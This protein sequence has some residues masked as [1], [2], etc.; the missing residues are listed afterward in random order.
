MPSSPQLAVVGPGAI[1]STFASVAE[2]AGVPGVALCGRTPLTRVTVRPDDGAPMVLASEVWT[3]PAPPR[4]PVDW[5]L[6]AVKAHQTEG[7]A[8]WLAS[9]C[10]P[11]TVVVVLQNGVEHRD[12]VAPYV[13]AATVLPAIVWCPAEAG[14]RSGGEQT[15]R[16]RGTPE[17]T[18][19]DEPAGHRLVELLEPG[20]ARIHPT[21][22]F[23][24]EAWRKLT[25]NAMAG[26]MVLTGRRSG[27]FR[28]AD[29][30]EL[31]IRLAQECI[32]VAVAEGA[33]LDCST[34]VTCA[35][36]FAGWPTDLGSSILCD[37]AAA[38]PLEWDARNGVVRRLAARHGIPTPVSDVIV[39]LLAA[40]SD[41]P[42]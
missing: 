21:A 30:R 12:T 28:R 27:M 18:V 14:P 15:I 6:L 19:P 2:R 1:G 8:P 10:G 3:D 34:A 41:D 40:A 5:L 20:G 35:D 22:D 42:S 13:G 29:I 32:A 33:E 9:L 39:P 25:T 23:L 37:R 4:R 36:R 38:R 16:L 24:T 26:L 11:D 7:A 31:A 17:L